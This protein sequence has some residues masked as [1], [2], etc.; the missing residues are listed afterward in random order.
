MLYSGTSFDRLFAVYTAAA[1]TP[2][3]RY[4]WLS[5]RLSIR[6]DNRVERTAKVCS[7]V[8]NE[9]PLIVQPVVQPGCTTGLTTGCIYDTITGCQTGFT[10][11]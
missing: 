10:T 2:F 4:N 8:L 11:G 9:Q 7:S 6:F 3:T 1:K 5:T